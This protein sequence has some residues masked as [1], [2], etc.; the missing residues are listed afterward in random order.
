[1]RFRS[2]VVTVLAMAL[3]APVFAQAEEGMWPIDELKKLDFKKLEKLG[4][5]L[6]AKEIYDGKGGGIAGAIVSF[7]G[8]TGSF[9]SPEGLILTNHHVTFTALQ[10][11]SSEEHNYIEEGF[12]A[13]RLEDEIPAHGYM[14]Y[15]LLDIE[16]VT[17]KVLGAVDDDMTDF[18]RYET[19]EQRI[20][21]VVDEGEKDRDV[22]CRVAAFFDGMIYKLITYFEIKDVRIAY[23]PPRS[24]GRPGRSSSRW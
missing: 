14:A 18:E 13:E 21:E 22:H 15:V 10:R 20:K 17:K 8:G 16:D 11:A 3:L 23:A 9:V 1:M 7:G 5:E 12:N 4:L 24:I 6:E 2:I 19:I